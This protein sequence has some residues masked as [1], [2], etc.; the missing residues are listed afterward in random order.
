MTEVTIFYGSWAASSPVHVCTL[1]PWGYVRYVQY[2]TVQYLSAC[3][4]PHPS[5]AQRLRSK[6]GSG[7][8]HS[9]LDRWD[10]C[11][12]CAS[13]ALTKTPSLPLAP[14]FSPTFSDLFVTYYSAVLPSLLSR[15]Y[16]LSFSL[17]LPSPTLHLHLYY[18]TYFS[19]SLLYLAQAQQASSPGIVVQQASSLRRLVS[20]LIAPAAAIRAY[21]VGAI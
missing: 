7:L 6:V 20:R 4:S 9:I 18:H 15:L 3:T 21:K 19:L 1:S 2:C 5:P 8:C 13:P 11:S 12:R 14:F 17:Y 10:G 16:L